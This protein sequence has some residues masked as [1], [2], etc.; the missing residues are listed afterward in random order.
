[1]SVSWLAIFLQRL[2]LVRCLRHQP[3]FFPPGFWFSI[4]GT[5]DLVANLTPALLV[6]TDAFKESKNR[7]ILH[8]VRDVSP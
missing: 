8:P 6:Y 4:P 7:G 2:S 5:D 1:M 3:P